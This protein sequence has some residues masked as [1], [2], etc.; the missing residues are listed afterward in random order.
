[1]AD[2]TLDGFMG[3]E[4]GCVAGDRVPAMVTAQHLLSLLLEARD[5]RPWGSGEVP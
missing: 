4:S 3:E 5:P 2:V 1:M